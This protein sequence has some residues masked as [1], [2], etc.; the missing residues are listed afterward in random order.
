MEDDSLRIE[1]YRQ[2]YEQ[3]RDLNGHMWKIPMIALT[4]TG[5]L[6]LGVVKAEGNIFAQSSLLLLAS[7]ANLALVIVLRRIR[8]VMAC[9]LG[10]LKEMAPEDFVD[11]QGDGAFCHGRNMVVKS[12]SVLL[13]LASVL[14]SIY[15][16]NIVNPC[17]FV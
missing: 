13:I 1:V 15:F 8:Y 14:S 12:F 9:I 11:A 2:H 17:G 6:W 7:V 10:K 16:I 4:L 5:G 3:F